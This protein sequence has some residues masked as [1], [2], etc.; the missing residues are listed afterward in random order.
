MVWQHYFVQTHSW[1]CLLL[2]QKC[3]ETTYPT[4]AAVAA[5]AAFEQAA[6]GLVLV[7]SVVHR[8]AG[9]RIAPGTYLVRRHVCKQQ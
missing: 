4:A 3:A 6:L 9:V 8:T 1:Y 2:A 5:A 7:W